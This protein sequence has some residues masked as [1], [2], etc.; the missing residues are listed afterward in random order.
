MKTW[1]LII[2]RSDLSSTTLVDAGAMRPA[3][4]QALLRAARVGLTTNNLT[5]CALGDA[6]GYWG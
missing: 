6:L 3:A 1:S 2:D 4:G 5:Y